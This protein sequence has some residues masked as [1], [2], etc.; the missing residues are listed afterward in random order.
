MEEE[1]DENGYKKI[2]L[3][4]NDL[5]NPKY[6]ARADASR[7]NASLGGLSQL[8]S[9]KHNWQHSSGNRHEMPPM[10]PEHQFAF[11][12]A[13][14]K[15][16]KG[17]PKPHSKDLALALKT[18]WK[19]DSCGKEGV[20]R[21]NFVRY[22]H[23]DGSCSQKHLRKSTL[24]KHEKLTQHLPSEF[25]MAEACEIASKLDISSGITYNFVKNNAVVVGKKGCNPIYTKNQK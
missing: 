23:E 21:G 16:H 2:N 4:L 19:C 18:E 12:S 5:N 8:R 11:S 14:G 20:G 17:K 22:G 15:T 3:D 10:S 24:V 7:E 1:L 13:G 25:T 9:G 6:S